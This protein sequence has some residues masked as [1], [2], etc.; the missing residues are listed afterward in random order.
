MAIAKL[1]LEDIR[2][3]ADVPGEVADDYRRNLHRATRG[4][5]RL[6]LF[7]GDQK[8]EHLNDDFFGP[9][10]PEEDADPEHL[11]RIA[12]QGTIGVFATQLGLVTRYGRD[13]PDV[14]YLVKINSKS[15]LLKTKTRDP[16]SWA[17]NSI[18]QVLETRERSGLNIVGVG[19]TVYVGSA[20][21]HEMFAEA[22]E[23]AFDAREAGLFSVFWMYPRGQSVADE[24]DPHVI[25]GAAGTAVCLGADFC[26]VNYPQR[27][28]EPRGELLRQAV[29]AAGRTG[30]ICAGGSSASP[31][32]FLQD[33]WD[34]IN[35][36]GAVGNATGRNI[37]QRTLTDAVR[38]CDAISAVTYAGA[39]VDRALRIFAGDEKFSL[40]G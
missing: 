15:H 9:G 30:L 20:Y 22:A 11:F 37:H 40:P 29:K 21:E 8:I 31:Q 13:Y 17:L 32:K 7:A 1:N 33:L 34:Q 35:V 4:T 23:L 19:Y 3:P 14:N 39:D 6:M 12:S 26:K 2:V 10:I 28:S 24:K 36:G 27:G 5:G 18:D 38:L 25:A 16:R